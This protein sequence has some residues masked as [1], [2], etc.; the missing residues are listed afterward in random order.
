MARVDECWSI[1]R[2]EAD[3]KTRK[4]GPTRRDAAGVYVEDRRAFCASSA[5][6]FRYDV[7]TRGQS[8][9]AGHRSHRALHLTP[10]SP[11]RGRPQR[12]IDLRGVCV[13]RRDRLGGLLREY[14]VAA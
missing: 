12:A 1:L 13:Q 11:T 2:A 4:S 14:D 7:R 5:S 6:R 10:P 8:I 9:I 3:E